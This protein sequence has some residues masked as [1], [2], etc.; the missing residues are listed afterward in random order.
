MLNT[1]EYFKQLDATLT[2]IDDEVA[3]TCSGGRIYF[4]GSDPDVILFEDKNFGGAA[5]RINATNGAGDDNLDNAAFGSGW[6]NRTS[7]IKVIRGEWQLFRDGNFKGPVSVRRKGNY[8]TPRAF[9]QADN[10][11]TGIR[12]IG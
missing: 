10:A 3:A 11:L 7:S 4:G 5:L 12:R 8:K 1:K 9:G 6:N 2:V